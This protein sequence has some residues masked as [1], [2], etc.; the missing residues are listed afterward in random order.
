MIRTTT[1]LAYIKRTIRELY[2]HSASTPVDGLLDP[3]WDRSVD[4]FPG[5]CMMRKSSA[6]SGAGDLFTLLDATGSPYGLIDQYI[7]PVYGI[8]EPAAIGINAITVWVLS[9]GSE[10]EV[11]SPAFDADATWTFPTDG[12][13]L[14]VHAYTGASS[15]DRGVLCPAGATGASTKPIARAIAR[16]ATNR[17]IIG[18]LNSSAMYG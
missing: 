4:I 5:M 6:A 8:D 3:A 15:S 18:G 11:M 1:A 16:P 12:T 14:L 10:F 17:L 7:A 13:P 9:P 2:S